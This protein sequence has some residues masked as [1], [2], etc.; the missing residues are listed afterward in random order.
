MEPGRCVLRPPFR[1]IAHE[2]CSP[3]TSSVQGLVPI[4]ALPSHPEGYMPFSGAEAKQIRDIKDSLQPALRSLL[5][6][7]SLSHGGRPL[8]EKAGLPPNSRYQREHAS[9]D[10]CNLTA[11]TTSLWSACAK[12]WAGDMEQGVYRSKGRDCIDIDIAVNL[13]DVFR[14]VLHSPCRLPRDCRQ[15]FVQKL[16]VVDPEFRLTAAKADGYREGVKGSQPRK[17]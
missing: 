11:S 13:V 4:T 15:D 5:L 2:P 9:A 16:L 10:F 17:M 6:H 14:T 3:K 1:S 8:L 7:A 12:R